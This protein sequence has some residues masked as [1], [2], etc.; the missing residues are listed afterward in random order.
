MAA[1]GFQ[2][3]T[4]GTTSI[5]VKQS[6]LDALPGGG[7]STLGGETPTPGDE[8]PIPGGPIFEGDETLTLT[9]SDPHNAAAD[10]MELAG[11]GE[12]TGVIIDS[13]REEKLLGS[14]GDDILQAD[15]GNAILD[16][17][18]GNDVLA[19][20]GLE[21]EALQD[22]E[23]LLAD[24]VISAQDGQVVAGLLGN[25]AEGQDGD[26][27]IMYGG[28]GNDALLGGG[29]ND[30]LYGGT[31]ND[32]LFG[33]RGD[34]Y[35]D[36]GR[37]DDFLFGGSGANALYGGEGD[38]IMVFHADN[39]VMDGGSGVDV[40]I[41]VDL[42]A[43]DTLDGLFNKGM[44]RNVEVIMETAP[45]LTDMDGLEA[46]GITVSDNGISLSEAWQ[47]ATSAPSQ[48]VAEAGYEAYSNVEGLTILVLRNALESGG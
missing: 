23:D 22:I 1:D 8:T 13:D 48:T 32:F 43:P 7:T 21:Q 46:L 19:P 16:G 4:N 29:G 40:L 28:A 47:A 20:A 37:G 10:Q 2:I 45:S 33:G 39:T 15:T 14:A 44:I 12:Y 30:E 34:D 18:A 6:A 24:G 26:S 36:G 42:A 5:L 41:G 25:L 3:Y 9:L 38:D 27:L 17:G 11:D 35:L 31:G